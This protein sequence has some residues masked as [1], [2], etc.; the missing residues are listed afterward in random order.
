MNTRMSASNQLAIYTPKKCTLIEKR[1]RYQL[2]ANYAS[3]VGYKCCKKLDMSQVQ[4]LTVISN[5]IIKQWIGT[6]PTQEEIDEVYSL[7][8]NGIIFR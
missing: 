2:P 8:E 6:S 4:G 3:K 5:P 1:K 7:M